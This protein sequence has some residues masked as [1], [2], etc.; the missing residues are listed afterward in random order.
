[1]ITLP[2]PPRRTDL[3]SFAIVVSLIVGAMIGGLTFLLF[4]S[5]WPA[6]GGGII[7]LVALRLG[8]QQSTR[9]TVLY[10]TWNKAAAK[11]A[12]CASLGVMGICFYI[13]LATVGRS[14]STLG[15][16]HPTTAKSFWI[17]RE[18]QGSLG[19]N[20]LRGNTVKVIPHRHWALALIIWV[21]KTRN[22]WVLCLLPFFFLLAILESETEEGTF[23]TS[24]YTLF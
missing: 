2:S 15:L 24:T 17:P 11:I 14:G 21:V 18:P 12:R 22:I 8:L 3:R 19:H 16:D 7:A 9:L 13:I 5:I 4:S 23:P 20:S 6:L 1:M 10:R